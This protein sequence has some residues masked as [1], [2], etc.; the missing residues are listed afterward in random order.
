MNLD[1]FYFYF[2]CALCY[3][4]GIIDGIIIHSMIKS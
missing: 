2:A 3:A 4:V 1:D